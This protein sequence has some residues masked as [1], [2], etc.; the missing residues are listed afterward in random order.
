[1]DCKVPNQKIKISMRILAVSLDYYLR[2]AL[3]HYLYL[4]I[5]Y[6]YHLAIV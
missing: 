3:T 1:M 5:V 2:T 4:I 6:F